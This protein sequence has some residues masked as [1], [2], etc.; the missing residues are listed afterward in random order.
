[1]GPSL[2]P[3]VTEPIVYGYEGGLQGRGEASGKGHINATLA[4]AS[5]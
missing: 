4:S 5:T 3:V 1:M 2:R